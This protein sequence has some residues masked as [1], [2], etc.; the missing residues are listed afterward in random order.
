MWWKAN[1]ICHTNILKNA[2]TL[3]TECSRGSCLNEDIPAAFSAAALVTVAQ[4]LAETLLERF[5][6]PFN[7]QSENKRQEELGYAKS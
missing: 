5:I 4:V 2:R 3:H 6:L 7:T 1:D